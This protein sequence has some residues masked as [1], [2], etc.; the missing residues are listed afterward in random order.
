MNDWR[1]L[2]FSGL[3][4][5]AQ[6][7]AAQA[8]EWTGIRDGALY[9]RAPR[10]DALQ[11]DWQPAWQAE[12]NAEHLYLQAGDGRLLAR[13][14]I[15]AAETRGSQRWALSPGAGDQR[16]EIPGYS[17]RL[18]RVRHAD[19]TAALFEPVKQHFCAELPA[20]TQLYFRV[21]AG[22][23]A[24][25]AGKYHGGVDGLYAQRLSD[26]HDLYLPL[27]RDS[28]YTR[29]DRIELPVSDQDQVWNLRLRGRG[30]A[31][32]WLDGS[33]N[34]FAQRPEHLFS[35]ELTPGHVGLRLHDEVA[36]PTPRL[37][38]G[39]PYTPPEAP[40]L[41][42]RLAPRAA[43]HY[44][45]VD[46]TVRRPH[47]EQAFRPLYFTRYG[48]DADSTLLSQTGRRSVLKADDTSR[49]G[50]AAWIDGI[51]ELG[52]A[53]LH[54][55]SFADEPNLSY[56]D[57]A[58]FA[59]YFAAMAR[60][61]RETA[62]AR[63]AG[64]R[65]A[66]PASSRLVNGPTTD[67]ARSRRGLDWAR[68][69]LEE[70]GEGID[71]LAWHEWMVRDLRATRVYRDSVRQAAQL[72]GLD[73]RGRPRKALLLEQ[74]NLS[75][76][77]N[78]SPYEQ[79]TRFAA[80][81]W[82]SVAINAAQDGLLEQLNWF[83]ATDDD[84]HF[85]GMIGRAGDGRY[86]LKPVGEAMAFMQRH[87]QEEVLRLDNDAFEVDA[88]AMRS[89]SRIV[90]FGVNKAPRRQEVR[91][92]GEP[93]ACHAQDPPRLQLFGAAEPGTG[94]VDCTQQPWRFSL[95]G[96]TLFVLEWETP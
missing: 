91:L 89:D 70:H 93:L 50:L 27:A 44:S 2:V 13:R 31:A 96:E 75:S 95:P 12:A 84:E 79:E 35:P 94:A 14:D 4:L 86:V 36:G 62:G 22:E 5:G 48:I 87:W 9:L 90:L 61:V 81:W 39:L 58:S 40:E 26:E 37:G 69:L 65:V 18:Y 42:A 59:R 64:I 3:L 24:V 66:V 29:S 21:R 57:Y 85:K 72:V 20:G 45:F 15:A 49:A 53:G 54:Y 60:Q 8:Q 10:D 52:G 71:A 51:R 73:E 38:V 77:N 11:I 74:T 34:L 76:G 82:A 56:P 30:K 33:A 23:R 19:D 41:L 28:H 92:S 55:I 6:L 1:I 67:G 17:F 25:L 83:L 47:H 88:L 32:F 46:V 80:L 43:N 63:E 16:L 68:R 7:P 78:V